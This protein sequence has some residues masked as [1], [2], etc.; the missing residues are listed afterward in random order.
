MNYVV[1][2]SGLLVGGV[3]GYLVAL[4]KGTGSRWDRR[5]TLPLVL[6]AGAA[7]LALIPVV[8]Q[9]RQ[10]LFG[11]YFLGMAGV[12]LFALLGI[13]VWRLGA[14]LLP[15]GSILAYFYFG[16]IVHEVD[17]IGLLVKAVEVAAI[18][19]VIVGVVAA[20][21]RETVKRRSPA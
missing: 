14:I 19:A 2:L 11:L 20:D 1:A 8:E 7:H 17:V 3:T 6:A 13:G 4:G 5:V 21:G 12:F 18:V 9:E 15:A 16:L 10:L